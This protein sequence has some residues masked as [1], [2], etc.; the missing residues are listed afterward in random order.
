MSDGRGAPSNRFEIVFDAYDPG[1]EAA[2]ESL[3]GLGNGVIFV[4][5]AAPESAVAAP[6]H[7][8]HYPGLYRAGGYDTATR[9]IDGEAVQHTALARLPDPFGLALAIGDG[10][11][12]TVDDA[13]LLTYRHALDLDAGVARRELLWRDGGGRRVRITETRLASLVEPQLAAL[14]WV[15]EAPDGPLPLR[16]RSAMALTAENTKV[17]RNRAYEGSHWDSIRG[18]VLAPALALV[19][20]G[21]EDGLTQVALAARTRILGRRA[22]VEACAGPELPCLDLAVLAAPGRPV[23]VEKT[24][25]VFAAEEAPRGDPAEAALGAAR[26]APGFARLE[27]AQRDAWTQLWAGC[28]IHAASPRLER[29]ARFHAFHLLQTVS[30]HTAAR[31]VGF[32]ARGW[33]EGY[34]GHIFW[35]EIFAYP[36]YSLRFPEIARALLL[37][38]YRRLPEA[39]RAAR[40]AG[41]RGA[42]FPWRSARSG[43]EETPPRQCNP[44]SGRWMRDNTA[45]QRHIGAA[46]AFNLW[47]HHL[48]T[49]DDELLF[50]HTGE[51][52]IEIARLWTSLATPD[53]AGR[54]HIRGVLG[55]DEYHDAYPGAARPGLDDNAYTNVMAAWTLCRA[56]D[57]LAMMPEARRQA[58]V[59]R[60]AIAEDEPA[61]W[62]ALSRRL[63]VPLIDDRVIAQF[64]GFEQLRPAGEAE[65]LRL[66]DERID[67]SLEARGDTVNAYQV[68]KQADV[69]MLFHL[70]RP[71]SL[72][73]LLARLGYRLRP[74]WARATLDFHLARISHESTLSRP[75]CAGALAAVD[76]ERSWRY[77]LQALETDLGPGREASTHQGL[78]LGAMAGTLEVL[79]RHYLG[80]EPV[81]HGLCL[82]PHPPSELDEV[83]LAVR[84]REQDLELGL[85]GDTLVL[86]SARENRAE[87]RVWHE[88]REMVLPPGDS[89]G[90]RCR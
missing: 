61:A 79:Q 42:L 38:R 52:L 81:A 34:Y 35:D 89:L 44:L 30:P 15:V 70:L 84:W 59:R 39:R 17:S 64:E 55:P 40:D 29:T 13:T 54:Y 56:L 87:L 2:R 50:G 46:I 19:E 67:W 48:V 14:R 5:A 78:H 57:L 45:L 20:A 36:F 8:R 71:A 7:S 53:A 24:V 88:E 22:T 10:P 25:A 82:T 9:C 37:Y 23:A 76:P 3:L 26:A 1:E 12:L 75:V 66:H 6:S 33:Q 63:A 73:A 85:H 32:P 74:G 43:A 4:R 21:S 68:T 18:R 86:R 49:G 47:H 65:A 28:R 80:L 27:R 31:D 83:T 60:L 72:E 16:L 77:Y 41:L 90:V 69:L 62:E 11:W 58:I 51:M